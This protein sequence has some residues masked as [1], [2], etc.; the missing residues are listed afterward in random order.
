MMNGFADHGLD[1]N[2][3]GDKAGG[4]RQ[5]IRTFDAFRKTTKGSL[6]QPVGP[7]CRYVSDLEIPFPNLYRAD[8]IN[9]QPKPN[10]HTLAEPPPAATLPSSSS[11]SPSSSPAVNF[12]GGTAAMKHISSPLKRVSLTKCKSILTLSSLCTATISISMF[13]TPAAIVS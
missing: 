9:R 8:S 7:G 12:Y 10:P 13:K 1:E 4:F 5:N 6:H 11:S 3:F 2:A